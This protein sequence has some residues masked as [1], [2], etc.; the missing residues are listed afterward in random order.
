MQF[1]LFCNNE[2]KTGTILIEEKTSLIIVT[3]DL[4]IAVRVLN[5]Y[6]SVCRYYYYK[7]IHYNIIISCKNVKI[8]SPQIVVKV[9]LIAKFAKVVA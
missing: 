3:K 2:K 5:C 8:A 6:T 4:V 7:E 9:A 1:T